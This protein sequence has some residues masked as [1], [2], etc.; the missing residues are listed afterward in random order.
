MSLQQRIAFEQNADWIGREVEVLIDGRSE[1]GPEWI[2]RTYADAPEVD[3]T[4]LVS[5]RGLSAG[6]F[7]KVRITSTRGYDLLGTADG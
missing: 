5:G 1:D 3:G 2:G 4:V 6:R 7:Y